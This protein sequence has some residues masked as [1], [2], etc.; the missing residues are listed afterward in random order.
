MEARDENNSV[1][2]FSFH[3]LIDTI[4][5]SE[6]F[7]NPFSFYSFPFFTSPSFPVLFFKILPIT[8]YFNHDH[9]H[10]Q[11]SPWYIQ[12]IFDPFLI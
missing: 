12:L 6:N 9:I 11:R 10:S 7:V 8:Q 2:E 5:V 4:I 1:F 3:V